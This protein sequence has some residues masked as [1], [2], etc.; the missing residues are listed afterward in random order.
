[1][2]RPPDVTLGVNGRDY[3]LWLEPRRALLDA[4]RDEC[5]LTRTRMGCE[6]GV[7]GAGTVLLEGA[8][9]RSCGVF[10]VQAQGGEIGTV[11]GLAGG[12]DLTPLQ[13]AF[14]RHHGR[15]CGF[16][17]PAFLMLATAILEHHPDLADENLLAALLSDLCR[18][19][20]HANNVAAVR[21]A[22]AAAHP[23]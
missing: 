19:T 4:P 2:S 23:R 16:C 1:M 5:G 12:G 9:M 8:P 6:H 20:G 10:A 22:L 14:I 17:T 7:C 21:A 3:R 18:F 15:Q 13:E 11:E